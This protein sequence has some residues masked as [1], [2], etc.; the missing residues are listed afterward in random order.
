MNIKHIVND[1]YLIFIK[2][3]LHSKP[4]ESTVLE[5]NYPQTKID[6]ETFTLLINDIITL[7]EFIDIHNEYNEVVTLNH[8]VEY[9]ELLSRF[10]PKVNNESY[11]LVRY[12]EFGYLM[13]TFVNDGD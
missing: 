7:D 9:Q 2:E 1:E 5:F 6:V 8:Y 13:V 10:R 4:K 12:D 11:L 3:L